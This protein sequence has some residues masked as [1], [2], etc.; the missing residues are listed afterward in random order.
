MGGL[1]KGISMLQIHFKTLILRSD[2][3][4]RENYNH[5]GGRVGSPARRYISTALP[6]AAR[7][8]C[9]GKGETGTGREFFILRMFRAH[10]PS[11]PL[12]RHLSEGAAGTHSPTVGGT[13]GGGGK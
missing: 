7:A 2:S 3:D 4:D 13:P 11:T 5:S 1:K 10:T 6:K 8:G 12:L 9:T